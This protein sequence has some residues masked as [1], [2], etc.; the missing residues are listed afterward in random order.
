MATH[1]SNIVDALKK[2]VIA[3]ESRKIISDTKK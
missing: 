3:F 1:D 2:R